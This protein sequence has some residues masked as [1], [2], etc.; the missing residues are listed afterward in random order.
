MW[1]RKHTSLWL[2][3][4]LHPIL[5]ELLERPND[6][7]FCNRYDNDPACSQSITFDLSLYIPWDEYYVSTHRYYLLPLTVKAGSGSLLPC[8]PLLSSCREMS[9]TL[10]QRRSSFILFVCTCFQ[11]GQVDSGNVYEQILWVLHAAVSVLPLCMRETFEKPVLND[12]EQGWR[13]QKRGVKDKAMMIRVRK[14]SM[15]VSI[16]CISHPCD[17]LSLHTA[18]MCLSQGTL[19]T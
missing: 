18:A 2:P 9:Q 3:H 5:K 4:T 11:Q 16:Y 10:C 15:L 12:N 6:C 14:L 7:I 13:R 1:K 19:Y 17:C 8:F